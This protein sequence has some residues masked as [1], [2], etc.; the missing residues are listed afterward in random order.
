[1]S[2]AKYQGTSKMS[3]SQVTLNKLNVVHE[4]SHL[5]SSSGMEI[6]YKYNKFLRG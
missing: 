5:G 4:V 3:N 2:N 1:M 6:Y